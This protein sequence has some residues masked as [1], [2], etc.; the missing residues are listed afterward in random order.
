MGSADVDIITELT[1][2]YEERYSEKTDNDIRLAYLLSP[3][4]EAL[5]YPRLAAYDDLE[6]RRQ[7]EGAPRQE[8]QDAVDQDR[9]SFSHHQ[10]MYFKPIEPRLWPICPL[11]VHLARYKGRPDF[12]AHQRLH[13]WASL[14]DDWE[15]IQRL[16]RD[17]SEFCNTLSPAQRRS[18]D[19]LQ[20]WWK[21][22]YCDDDL[23]NATIAHLQSRRPFWT[24][25]NPSADENLC[26]VAS[27]V[28]TDTS[29]YHSH[30]FRLF[31]LEFHPQSWEP[32]LCQV[33]L[34]MLQ[35][36]RYRSSC[37]A[38]I[39]KL[40][41]PVLHPSRSLADG[42]V[43]YPIVVQNDAEHQTITSAQASI[44]PYYLWDNKGQ[45][46]VAVKDL[47][48]CPPYVCIS[49][50]WG[51]WRTRTD[52]TVPGV[53]WLVPENTRYD[54]RDLPG[55]LKELG[56]RFIWFDLFCI[57]QDRSERAALEIASQASIF[58]GSSNCI[59]WI[60]D[61]DS[62]H[63]V[64]AALDWMSLRSQSLTSTRDTNAI[65]ERMAEVTQAAKVPMELLKRKPRDETENLADLADDVTA[66]EPTFWMSSLWT[67]QECILCPEIQLYSR[68]WARL[69]DRGGSAISLR[70][71]MVFLRD[72]LL[73]NRLEEPIAA[74]FSDPVK[75]DSEVA[76]DPGR[77][78]YLNVSNWKFPRAVRDLYYLCMMTRLDNALTSGSPTT[79]LTNANLR[80]CTSSRAPAIMSA[81]GVTDWYLEGMQASKSG[82]AT[83]P[84][85]LV[86][87]TYPLAFLRE[88]SRKFGAMFYESIANNLSRKSTTQELRRVLLR[89]ERGGTM[90][91][92]SRS[93]GWFS[94]ISGSYEHT[95]IDRRDHE[96]VA[97][98]MVNE[99]GSV[100][101]PSA[102]IAM[103]S[104]D[105]P[106]TRKLSGTI[107]CVLAQTDAEGK[108][109]MYT[110][111][112]KDML[113]TLKDLSYSSRRIYAVALYQDMSF[114]HGVLLEKVPLSIFGK[115]YLNKIGSFVLTDMSLPPTSKVDWKV[116]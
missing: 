57:P 59:A 89:N 54:V 10:N 35:S 4:W 5:V 2:W 108:L 78:L 69:E 102:G 113:S 42:Q 96:A 110:S 7:A 91:P 92:I 77:K 63:G 98:W 43:T 68:T 64:L 27:R 60:N 36:A 31:L 53:P 17:E 25:N 83:S 99:D 12:D 30:L 76:N 55:Q 3:E 114:L 1:Q 65:K 94:N 70:T 52:T 46:T 45:K 19:L 81:V 23:L 61:V 58:K 75:H 79:I 109:E 16:V 72:T 48:E 22:A 85:P 51:R 34:F 56:Y 86:F 95:Y 6:K 40:S 62:W 29:L 90:L 100:S 105:E 73:H 47:P 38:T 104:D 101:M 74:P 33:K 112:V 67:L 24:I 49:H 107:N 88:A 18:F 26:L 93:K 71:L 82:K 115:H 80:Q 21:A 87:E 15:E 37:I 39:Q 103:T 20:S 97:D 106:G 66:G 9:R 8:W 44:N 41:Y 116:L 50:T 14:L 28:K 13:G 11:W 84:Q 111:V 32:F